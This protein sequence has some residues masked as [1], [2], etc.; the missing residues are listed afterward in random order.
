M[1]TQKSI[2]FNALNGNY[3]NTQTMKINEDYLN[4][5]L[6]V[7]IDNKQQLWKQVKHSKRKATAIV[8]EALTIE[9]NEQIKFN[10]Y[11]ASYYATSD[12]L[13][14][15]LKEY[16]RGYETIAETVAYVDDRRNDKEL[17]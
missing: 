11:P 15:W 17:G 9:A 13:K 3:L 12:Q 5:N 7:L 1:K 6:Q 4:S 16:G 2:T 8:W 14:T 10:E